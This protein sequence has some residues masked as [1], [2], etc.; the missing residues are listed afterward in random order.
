MPVVGR[1]DRDC[2]DRLVIE[3]PAEVLLDRGRGVG[4]LSH[5]VDGLDEHG[6]I[7]VANGS[8]LRAGIGGKQSREVGTPVA[9]ADH[10]DPHPLARGGLAGSPRK[11]Q[12]TGSGRADE[13]SPV[14]LRLH[15]WCPLAH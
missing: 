14:K 3:Q 5:G 7:N 13:V 1:G 11:N 9:E 12:Q 15:R 10:G 4:D 8:E 6:V 2:V